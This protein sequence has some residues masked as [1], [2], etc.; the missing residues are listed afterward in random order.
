VWESVSQTLSVPT[1]SPKQTN[2]LHSHKREI[3]FI[4]N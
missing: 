3:A 2:N 4:L 1:A